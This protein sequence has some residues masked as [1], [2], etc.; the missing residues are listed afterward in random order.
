MAVRVTVKLFG[1][2]RTTVG[3][4]Q[5]ALDLSEGASVRDAVLACGLPDRVD[6]W[7]L[8]GGERAG[9]DRALTDGDELN[10]FQPVGGG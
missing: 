8:V 3:A 7:A 4:G 10:L 5:V 6:I 9:R 1:A 2:L